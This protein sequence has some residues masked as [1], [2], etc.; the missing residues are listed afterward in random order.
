MKEQFV[1]CREKLEHKP[2]LESSVSFNPDEKQ[3]GQHRTENTDIKVC[4]SNIRFPVNSSDLDSNTSS[5]IKLLS[6]NFEAL[7][8]EH[9]CTLSRLELSSV[10]RSNIKHQEV[11]GGTYL[12]ILNRSQMM[13][14]TPEVESCL[15]ASALHR[16]KRGHLVRCLLFGMQQV[17]THGVPSVELGFEPEAIRSRS[18]QF[19]TRPS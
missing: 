10:K 4:K 1:Q 14:T 12:S 13:K 3:E 7:A 8:L 17:H 15:E 5:Q 18:R 19:T 11:Y 16:L 9:S 2:N 6:F